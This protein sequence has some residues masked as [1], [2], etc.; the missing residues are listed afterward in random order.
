MATTTHTAI[1]PHWNK[2]SY[3]RP[4]IH[5][6]TEG[7]KSSQSARQY[8]YQFSAF[9]KY[10][11][12][13]T[14]ESDLVQ[15]RKRES[16]ELEELI[17]DFLVYLKKQKHLKAASIN[18]AKSAIV[19]FFK[20]NR[21]K[22]DKDWISGYVPAEESYK[23]D[24]PY[25]HDQIQKLLDACSEDRIRV[26]VLLMVSTSMR[27]GA[28]A[29]KT[30]E[31]KASV[32]EVGDLEWLPPADAAE[33]VGGRYK[34]FVYNRSK[35]GRYLTYCSHEC[36]MMIKR[37]LEYRRECGEVISGT[38]PLIREQFDPSDKLAI[39]QPRKI[40]QSS[41]AKTITKA[42]KKARLKTTHKVKQTHGFR[43]FAITMVDQ[44]GVKDSHR[45]YLTGHAQVGQDGSYVLP[46]Q[47]A[48]LAE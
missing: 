17:S 10:L 8:Q 27:V 5:Y 41:L 13:T 29:Y 45:R 15:L 31:D 2:D 24:E 21:V 26:A 42:L 38:S 7:L 46:T 32:L 1:T 16:Q 30:Q 43:K 39:S 25:T 11:G 14:D 19:H 22:L 28:L 6:V 12:I 23:E 18:L 20:I 37:Y 40:T 47:E 36:A 4:K 44:A 34:I 9:L 48:L 35:S 3:Y 33:K